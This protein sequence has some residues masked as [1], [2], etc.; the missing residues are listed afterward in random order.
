MNDF[1]YGKQQE[2][3]NWHDNSQNEQREMENRGK[4]RDTRSV[5]LKRMDSI[6]DPGKRYALKDCIGSGIYSN[7]YEGSDQQAGTQQKD[8]HSY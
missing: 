8:I 2:S 3:N 7:V 1:G 6:Q 4:T 5:T